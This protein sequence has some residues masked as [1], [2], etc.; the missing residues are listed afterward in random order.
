[1]F[2]SPP[3][4]SSNLG[5]IAT[6]L[7]RTCRLNPPKLPAPSGRDAPQIVQAVL[8][9][10]E[11]VIST[12]VGG[13]DAGLVLTDRRVIAWRANG[14][15]V[16]MALTDIDRV[17]LDVRAPAATSLLL[18]IA[19]DR[20][21]PPLALGLHPSFVPG[22]TNFVHALREAVAAAHARI[23]RATEAE[24]LSLGT[25]SITQFRDRG[26]SN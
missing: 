21:A 16:P 5:T 17:H 4:R 22:G 15:G 25:M 7:E 2:E 3:W 18:L 6:Q 19:R 12:I 11:A 1:M 9:P 20:D 24:L 14:V 13:S 23:G 8:L 26:V 10:G